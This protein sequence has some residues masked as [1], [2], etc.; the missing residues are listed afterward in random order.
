MAL[1]TNKN[2]QFFRSVVWESEKD[3]EGHIGQLADRLFGETSIYISIKRKV[4]KGDISCI[5]DAYVLDLADPISP[6]LY[7]IEIEI[8]SHDLYKHITEQLIRFAVSFSKDQLPV[9][10]FLGVHVFND[11]AFRKKLLCA[12]KQSKAENLDAYLDLAVLN[13]PFNGLVVIDNRTEDLDNVC[14]VFAKPISVLEVQAFKSD[15]GEMLYEIETLYGEEEDINFAAS[16]SKGTV[17]KNSKKAELHR[18]RRLTCDTLVVPARPE[19]FKDTF[20]GRNR[21]WAVRISPGMLDRIKYLAAYQVRPISAVTHIAEVQQIRP[22]GNEGKYELVFSGPA[23]K[24]KQIRLK[25]STKAPY[26]PVYV[27]RTDLLK[28]RSFEDALRAH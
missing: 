28:A 24:I 17:N 25:K 23:K 9:R 7:V 13:Q 27:R 8:H 4:S 2:G 10:R 1:I 22:Y 21:W 26:G 6:K 15:K 18:Q 5:P 19:G 3:F 16:G 11:S 14:K 20:L 12:Q